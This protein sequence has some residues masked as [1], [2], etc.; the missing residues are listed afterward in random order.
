MKYT[1]VSESKFGTAEKLLPHQ[2]IK[3]SAVIEDLTNWIGFGVRAQNSPTGLGWSGNPQYLFIVKK[4]TFEMQKFGEENYLKEY[5][6]NLVKAGEK[7]EYEIIADNQDDGSVKVTVKIDGQVVAEYHDTESPF[8]M[9]GYFEV[10]G[11]ATGR[12]IEIYAE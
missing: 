3:F 4:D 6:N 1:N 8:V 7:H 9:P 5:P 10:Y 2:I 11:P 12:Y